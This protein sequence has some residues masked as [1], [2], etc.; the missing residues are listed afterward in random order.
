MSLS[1]TV[2]VTNIAIILLLL[3][4]VPCWGLTKIQAQKYKQQVIDMN[5]TLPK[6]INKEIQLTKVYMTGSTAV[7]L[8]KSTLYEKNKMNIK[9]IENNMKPIAAIGL[10]T[11]HDSLITLKNGITFKYVF[12]DKNG[13]YVYEYSVAE[14]DCVNSSTTPSKQM[15]LNKSINNSK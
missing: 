3:K 4:I 12:Y 15:P 13:S 8:I 11:R 6:M 2:A 9:N 10:C 1:K 14:K 5:K 7:Y